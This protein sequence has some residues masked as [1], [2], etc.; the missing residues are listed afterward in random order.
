MSEKSECISRDAI[1]KSRLDEMSNRANE[2][3]VSGWDISAEAEKNRYI[4]ILGESFRAVSLDDKSPLCGFGEDDAKTIANVKEHFL[5][6][7]KD[8][9][10][11]N[12]KAKKERRLQSWIIK[13]ALM[14]ERNLLKN[15]LFSC[16]RD[17][18]DELLF[19][20]DEVS[21]GDKNHGPTV[22][23][24]LLAV[25]VKGDEVFLSVIELKS[26]RAL[27]R[28][29]DQLDNA[30]KEIDAHRGEIV[31]LMKRLTSKEIRNFAVK[32]ILVWP[33]ATQGERKDTTEKRKNSGVDFIE[34]SPKDFDHPEGVTSSLLKS[35]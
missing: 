19:A 9:S 7:P 1:I 20:I 21:F 14:N 31:E 34:Y 16:L 8:L 11:K 12:W 30:E 18:F 24:D 23:C 3:H 2:I 33:A 15:E 5:I 32:K 29:L 13:H 22:R 26:E 35:E 10:E 25:G 27:D 28:L 6:K 4:R 17:D